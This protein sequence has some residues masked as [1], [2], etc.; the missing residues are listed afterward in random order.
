MAGYAA[1]AGSI[2][3][4]SILLGAI[5]VSWTPVHIWSVALRYRQDYAEAK[6]PMLPV[7]VTESRAVKLI[8][9]ASI[10][11]VIVSL[12]PV[13]LHLFGA[14]YLYSAAVLGIGMLLL[15]LWLMIKPKGTRAWLVFKVSGLYLGLLFLAIL[16]D[17]LLVA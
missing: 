5:V 2:D 7:I 15:S 3:L 14:V 4:K 10:I 6:V 12:L 8:G 1:Y 9:L 16:L 17:S 11:S 13:A